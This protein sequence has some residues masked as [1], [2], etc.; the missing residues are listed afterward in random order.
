M[1]MHRILPNPAT[2]KIVDRSAITLIIHT[3]FN[4]R[5][6][7]P[8]II[9]HGPPKTKYEWHWQAAACSISDD[10]LRGVHRDRGE[11]ERDPGPSSIR[12][13]QT[14]RGVW[15]RSRRKL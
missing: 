11:G 12:I 5:K 7:N 6:K 15:A 9:F 2:S 8:L 13:L 14:S 4:H 10:A 3:S 1:T